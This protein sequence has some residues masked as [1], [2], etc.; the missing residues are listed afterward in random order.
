[1]T[2]AVAMVDE[3]RALCPSCAQQ[4]AARMSPDPEP[5][6][7]Q[8]LGR[9]AVRA[10][11]RTLGP[12]P[13]RRAKVLFKYLVLHRERPVHKE[14]LMEV[15]WPH[16]SAS[17]ARNSLNVAIHA[18]RRFLREAHADVSHVLFQ[19]DSYSLDPRL[20][21]RV[22]AEE[23]ER[24]ALSACSLRAVPALQ[25]A[26]ALYP[27]PLFDDDPYEEWALDRRR[28]LQDTYVTV[29][30]LLRDHH[31]AHG[32]FGACAAVARRIL[33]VEP[34][35]EE[36]HRALMACYARKRQHHLALRQYQDCVRILRDVL[37]T[38]PDDLTQRLNASIRRHEAV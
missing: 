20:A 1:M 10:G 34:T 37:C 28:E 7:V 3:A 4:R 13:H 15:F 6:S 38:R 5:L 36:T 14:I 21:V 19:D 16:V 11:S 2:E 24:Q 27:G 26:D 23:W 12:W 9:F 17:A 29:L 18:L 8:C 31:L 25:A 30:E 22:D 32:D 33:A 35:S